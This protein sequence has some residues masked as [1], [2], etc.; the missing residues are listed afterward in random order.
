MGN[1]TEKYKKQKWKRQSIRLTLEISIEL[2]HRT[3]DIEI[4]I[5]E[6]ATI[7]LI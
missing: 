7:L 5:G 3:G 6:Q 2:W 1:V 4:V